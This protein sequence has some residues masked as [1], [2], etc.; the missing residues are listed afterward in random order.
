MGAGETFVYLNSRLLP[1]AAAM[2]SVYDRAFAFGDAL[3]ETLK[4]VDGKPVFFEDHYQRLR[5]GMKEAGF[6]A[7]LEPL[8]LR[9]QAL[10]LAEANRIDRGRLR[11]M[12]SR[13]TP[14]SPAGVDPGDDLTPTLLLTAEPFAGHPEEIYSRGVDCVTVPANRGS[15]AGLKSTS[16]IASVLSRRRAHAAGAFEAIFTSGHGR[17]LEGSISNIFFMHGGGLMTAPD[18]LPVLAGVTRQKVIEIA[19]GEGIPLVYGAPVLEELDPAST[20]VFLTGSVLGVC[21]V[22]DIDG[23]SFHLDTDLTGLLRERLLALEKASID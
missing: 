23:V 17:M 15:Y 2:V 10:A 19:A 22:R 3:I 5:Q 12:L 1:A 13:G 6:T 21:P 9:N 8:G 11:I 18:D 14:P 16:L 7:T 4:L 20:T